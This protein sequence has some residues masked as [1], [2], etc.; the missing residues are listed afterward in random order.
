MEFTESGRLTGQL[1]DPLTG[2][3]AGRESIGDSLW[4]RHSTMVQIH[5]VRVAR[6][7]S[8]VGTKDSFRA[9]KFLTIISHAPKFPFFFGLDFVA[10][11]NP[12]KFAPNLP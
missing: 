5:L 11:K 12:A 4:Q 3:L 1:T 7:K 8:E 10:P 2:A 6:L 9:T